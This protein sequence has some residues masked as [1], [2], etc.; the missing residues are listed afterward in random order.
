MQFIFISS[1]NNNGVFV[2]TV[3][4]LKLLFTEWNW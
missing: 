4:I 1:S 3:Q 2:V